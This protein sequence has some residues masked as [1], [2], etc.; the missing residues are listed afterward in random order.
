[1]FYCSRLDFGAMQADVS[2]GIFCIMASKEN[3]IDL[4]RHLEA[5][6]N[7]G[8]NVQKNAGSIADPEPYTFDH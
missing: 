8:Q 5:T 2:N 1:M 3:G 4:V 7:I 6:D